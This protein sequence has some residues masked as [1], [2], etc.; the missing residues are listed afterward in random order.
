MD[1]KRDKSEI[2]TEAKRFQKKNSKETLQGESEGVQMMADPQ[3]QRQ[4][5]QT[6]AEGLRDGRVGCWMP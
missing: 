4:A 1:W 5:A 2:D 3:V 6:G